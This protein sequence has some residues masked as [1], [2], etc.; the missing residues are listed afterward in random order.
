MDKV[1]R[2]FIRKDI[3]R[4]S[5]HIMLGNFWAKVSELSNTVFDYSLNRS[6]YHANKAETIVK[7]ISNDMECCSKEAVVE[8]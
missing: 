6:K 5:G 8:Q 1:T 2:K 7:L 3:T 4:A